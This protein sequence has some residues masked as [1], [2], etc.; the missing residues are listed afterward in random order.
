[1][2]IF[3]RPNRFLIFNIAFF[4]I[5]EFLLTSKRTLTRFSL[6]LCL[7][8]LFQYELHSLSAIEIL[9]IS[10]V[11]NYFLQEK[12]TKHKIQMAIIFCFIYS[13]WFWRSF[14]IAGNVP[15]LLVSCEVRNCVLSAKITFSSGKSTTGLSKIRNCEKRL[16]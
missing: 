8:I 3:C 1:M 16:L 4:Q 9:N 12:M 11:K 5:F 13:I 15:P 14:K 10:F 6:T 2:F 7:F